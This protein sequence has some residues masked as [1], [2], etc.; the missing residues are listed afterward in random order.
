MGESKLDLTTTSLSP[1]GGRVG[2][3][4]VHTKPMLSSL[5]PFPVDELA[6]GLS[7]LL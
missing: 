3:E 2:K 1:N 6:D 4:E 5:A 7:R